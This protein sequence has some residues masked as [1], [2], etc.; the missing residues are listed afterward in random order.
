MKRK[1]RFYPHRFPLTPMSFSLNSKEKAKVAILTEKMKLY[2]AALKAFSIDWK[3]PEKLRIL[4]EIEN[5]YLN[6]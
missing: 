5:D 1:N 3:N 4:K 2:K 6:L